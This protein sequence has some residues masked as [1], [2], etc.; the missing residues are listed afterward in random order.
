VKAIAKAVARRSAASRL[1]KRMVPEIVEEIELKIRDN[2]RP[3]W[4][5]DQIAGFLKERGI[6]ISYRNYST[7]YQ[8]RE[9]ERRYLEAVFWYK[10]LRHG[11]TLQAQERVQ[12]ARQGYIPNRT[13]ISERAPIVDQKIRLGA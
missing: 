8:G 2:Q 1:P 12:G 13:D 10:S 11:G 5:P 6:S 9:E 7:T 4:S 3:H